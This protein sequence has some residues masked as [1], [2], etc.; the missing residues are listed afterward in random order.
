MKLL[1]DGV[2]REVWIEVLNKPRVNN[3]T[4]AVPTNCVFFMLCFLLQTEIAKRLNA[5]IA[6]ILPFLSQE[7]SES[8]WMPVI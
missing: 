1:F 3:I 4:P 8:M 6:Q 5:M 2:W 7:V